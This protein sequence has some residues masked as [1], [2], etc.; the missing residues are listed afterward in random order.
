MESTWANDW[1]L[2]YFTS[3][4]TLTF[5]K[6]DAVLEMSPTDHFEHQDGVPGSV[7]GYAQMQAALWGLPRAWS[8]H[9]LLLHGE[10][11][12]N[13][14]SGSLGVG[15]VKYHFQLKFTNGV[16]RTLPQICP[17]TSCRARN[18]AAHYQSS[19]SCQ[20]A[21]ICSIQPHLGQITELFL[22]SKTE[23]PTS[24]CPQVIGTR[25]HVLRRSSVLQTPSTGWGRHH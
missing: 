8:C 10:V 12:N 1:T 2:H 9:N 16:E 5:W 7:Q 18:P 6:A 17:F 11:A 13:T 22:E 25:S 4:A 23:S 15:G 21:S 3:L 24:S 20:S 19:R 14:G